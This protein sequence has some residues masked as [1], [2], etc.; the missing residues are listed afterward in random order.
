[1]QI[2]RASH[3]RD[4]PLAAETEGPP[5]TLVMQ[6]PFSLALTHQFGA[7]VILGIATAHWRG[8]RPREYVSSHE[9][10]ATVNPAYGSA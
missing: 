5:R 8:L 6:V 10:D 4:M 7:V 1:M 2:Y 3:A 9:G